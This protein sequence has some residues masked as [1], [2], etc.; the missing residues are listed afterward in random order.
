MGATPSEQ[1]VH[2][3]IQFIRF[4]TFSYMPQTN[5]ATL[6][7]HHL[8]ALTS[9]TQFIEFK[10]NLKRIKYVKTI[11]AVRMRSAAAKNTNIEIMTDC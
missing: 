9:H 5:R 7:T 11:D 3:E 6:N 4:D 10:S 8:A 1:K 2:S